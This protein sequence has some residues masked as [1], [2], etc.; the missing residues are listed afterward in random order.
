MLENPI[1]SII[2][3]VHNG[4]EYTKKCLKSLSAAIS[5]SSYGDYLNIIIVDDGS[6]DGTAEWINSNYLNI[7]VLKGDGNL[8]W[9]GAMN[10]GAKFALQRG[11]QYV[12]IINND[13]T[14]KD[15]YIEKLVNFSKQKNYNIIGSKVIEK[16]TGHIW[17]LGTDYNKKTGE[18]KLRKSPKEENVQYYGIDTLP[19][20]GTLISRSVFE[21]IGFWNQRDFPQYYGDSD[22]I[23]RATEN[24]IDAYICLDCILWNSTEHTGILHHHNSFLM[25][26]KSIYD[27]KSDY[28]I[29][30]FI[31][32][33]IRH[34]DSYLTVMYALINKYGRYIGGYLKHK[35]VSSLRIF[36]KYV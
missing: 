1:I 10:M 31:K 23:L 20:M 35:F 5:N 2:C 6:T 25:L 13:N 21:K 18:L 9:S 16:D 15:D 19:G 34:G 26:I 8:W 24:K 11:A 30:A 32:F 28:N 27:I 12:L 14:F 36:K 33:T 4:L 17:S 3:P 7:K 29:L 22:F